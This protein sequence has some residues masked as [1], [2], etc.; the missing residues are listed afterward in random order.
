MNR[1]K[2]A[3]GDCP[4]CTPEGKEWLTIAIDP[5]HDVTVEL[6]GFPDADSSP[7]FVLVHK[8][9]FTVSPPTGTATWGCHVSMPGVTSM[10]LPSITGYSNILSNPAGFPSVVPDTGYVEYP[11]AVGSTGFGVPVGPIQACA[12]TEPFVFGNTNYIGP[13]PWVVPFGTAPAASNHA[14]GE[15]TATAARIIGMAFE[16]H[17]TTPKLYQQGNVLVYHASRTRLKEFHWQFDPTN[18]P[19]GTGTYPTDADAL[20]MPPN[21]LQAA[22]LIPNSRTWEASKGCYVVA[23]LADDIELDPSA[24]ANGQWNALISPGYQGTIPAGLML[25]N[26]TKGFNAFAPSGAIFSGLN[27]ANGN[28]TI[29]TRII[30]EYF[31]N[32]ISDPFL[33]LSTPSAP[34]DALIMQHYSRLIRTLPPGVPVSMNNAGDWFRMVLRVLSESRIPSMVSPLFGA[35]LRAVNALVN[36]QNRATTV[37]RPRRVPRPKTRARLNNKKKMKK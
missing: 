3:L 7:S 5:F 10:S 18:L 22:A 1:T 26:G 12:Y 25:V 27:S 28:L 9:Q 19:V 16:V 29:N 17:D 20:F 31:P 30:Y 36:N 24:T 13:Q 8:Q 6:M 21:N 11:T 34:Y 4:G 15:T 32:N 33:P 2:L 14:F 23:R 35:G 37:A